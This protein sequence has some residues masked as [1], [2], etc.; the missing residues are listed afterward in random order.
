MYFRSTTW[1]PHLT[2]FNIVLW[3]AFSIFESV[4]GGSVVLTI[5]GVSHVT[6]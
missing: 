2:I 5:E 4:R 1:T 6:D 3:S